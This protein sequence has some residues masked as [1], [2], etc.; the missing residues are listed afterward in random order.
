VWRL[1]NSLS[2][3]LGGFILA[4]GFNTGNRF[5]YDVPW[6]GAVAFYVAGIALL[7]ANFRN[8]KTKG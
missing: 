6:L 3:I 5:L 2:T 7:Y 8:V 1:P 4:T